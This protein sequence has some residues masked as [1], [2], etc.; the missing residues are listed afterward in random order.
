MCRISFT[1]KVDVLTGWLYGGIPLQFYFNSIF[2]HLNLPCW[3]SD[4][5][6]WSS[7]LN[8]NKITVQKRFAREA[9]KRGRVWGETGQKTT[10]RKTID[11]KEEFKNF[12]LIYF[13]HGGRNSHYSRTKGFESRLIG[14][15]NMTRTRC[16]TPGFMWIKRLP[17]FLM[18][19]GVKLS[20]FKGD[21]GKLWHVWVLLTWTDDLPMT[22]SDARFSPL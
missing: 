8:N 22:S 7:F 5:R 6:M 11:F 20:F 1:K 2:D 12:C 21:Y 15:L 18:N 19:P 4:L 9:G 13:L 3:K 17:R 14:F 10:S 16:K